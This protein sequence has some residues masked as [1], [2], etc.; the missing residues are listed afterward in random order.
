MVLTALAAVVVVAVASFFAMRMF[1]APPD[2][3]DLARDRATAKGLYHL[4]IEP[5]AGSIQQGSLHNWIVTVKSADGQPV[6]GARLSVDGGM[7][8]HGHGLPTR[9]QASDIGDGRYRVEGV[10]FNMSGWWVLK[11]G[12][13]GPA[14]S[15]AAEFNL[16]L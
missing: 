2:D 3:L 9:P 12:V 11:L 6:V 10:R 1:M 8:Q 15:D 4:G 13:D 16:V 7:P 5:E 14:G